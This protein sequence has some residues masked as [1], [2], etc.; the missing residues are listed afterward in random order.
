MDSKQIIQNL[1]FLNEELKK[2]NIHGDLLLLGGAVMVTQIHN[3]K[4]TVDIDVSII[5]PNAKMYS[6]VLKAIETVTQE[7]SLPDQWLND[8]VSIITDQVGRPRQLKPWLQLSNLTA[9]VPDLYYMMAL[10]VFSGRSQDYRDIQALARELKVSTQ[11]QCWEIM[12]SYI[13]QH[14]Q[15]QTARIRMEDAINRCFKA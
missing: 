11:Q 5:A 13:P 10:K 7:K 3:R 8:D 1:G 12:N 9:Y 2:G 15:D 6:L 4:S 14:L